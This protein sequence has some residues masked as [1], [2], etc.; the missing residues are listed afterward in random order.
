V[1]NSGEPGPVSEVTNATVIGEP[2][3]D[4]PAAVDELAVVLDEE[5]AAPISETANAAN[6]GGQLVR[7]DRILVSSGLPI[8]VLVGPVSQDVS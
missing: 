3:G 1:V 5:H 7:R 8:V 6:R 4:E 2:D